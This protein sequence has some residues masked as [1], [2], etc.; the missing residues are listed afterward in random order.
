MVAYCG[1]D[2]E[3][4]VTELRHP[5]VGRSAPHQRVVLASLTAD[6]GAAG[7][8]GPPAL[9]TLESARAAE[10]QVAGD[11]EGAL[12]DRAIDAMALPRQQSLHRVRWAAG[13][14]GP[15]GLAAAGGAGILR[16]LR[17]VL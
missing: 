8:S 1:A 16:V 7:P 14:D 10:V 11:A 15:R 4:A 13:D 17:V 5:R 6:A 9:L 3:L 12:N 2:G